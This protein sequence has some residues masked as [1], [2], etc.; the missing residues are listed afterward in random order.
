VLQDWVVALTASPLIYLALYLVV[1]IDGFF[2]PIPSESVV[3]GL[4]AVAVTTGAPNLWLVLAVAAAGAFTGD[5]IAYAMGRRVHV[6]RSRL[7]RGRRAQRTL[8]WAEHA[9]AVRGASFIIGARY[10]PVGRVAVSMTAGAVGFPRPR[11]MGLTALGAVSWAFY[12]AAIGIGAG[13][14]LHARPAV[15]VVVGVVGGTLIGLGVD[16]VLRRVQGRP[17]LRHLGAEPAGSAPDAGSPTDAGAP[18]VDV[19]L[20]DDV[21]VDVVLHDDVLRDETL[22]DGVLIEPDLLDPDLLD[23]DLLAG[24]GHREPAAAALPGTDCP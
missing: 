4:S 14:W 6:R 20:R 1:T 18:L 23:G 5:Q 11:F 9:L 12:S 2:P 16:A 22:L 3:I 19:A 8:D 24:R 17:R 13:A 15:A 21:L 7:L 10:I